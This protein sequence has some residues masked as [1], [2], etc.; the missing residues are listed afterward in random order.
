MVRANPS[1]V[2]AAWRAALAKR[3][4]VDQSLDSRYL[5]A[6]RLL[7]R[8]GGASAELER[9]LLRIG[10]DSSLPP[11][12]RVLALSA[13]SGG[14]QSMSP[15]LFEFLLPLVERSAH[16]QLC[17]AVVE[18]FAASKL[19]RGQRLALCDQLGQVGPLEADGLLKT[20]GKSADDEVGLR[21]I[22][23][24]QASAVSKSLP[25]G[26]LRERLQKFGP[27]VQQQAA[28]LY[29][30]LDVSAAQ[31]KEKLEA[32]LKQLPA[33]DIRR[34]QMVFHS[35]K[36][37]CASC[38]AIGYT[39]RAIGP[40]LTRIGAVRSERDLLESV[41]FPSN[42]FVQGFEPSVVIT[43]DGITYSGLLR[44]NATDDYTLITGA[45]QSVRL[46]SE[47]IEETHFSAVSLMPAGLDGQL[48]LQQLADLLAYLRS[49][50]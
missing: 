4:A 13:L 30:A 47:D 5:Q 28:A 39:D 37:A 12:D 15:E 2:P 6:A 23:T 29:A 14:V 32:T 22:A 36:A 42:S 31:Q 10:G 3:L 7:M 43:T 19:S 9:E 18:I 33:G 44:R 48:T 45:T 21:L 34:G 1:Q 50:R 41:L 11:A 24:L 20:L 38:H 17:S 49:C 27:A 8:T 26:L 25:V 35:A 40:D 46:A 16:P